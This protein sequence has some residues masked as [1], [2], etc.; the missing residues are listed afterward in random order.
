MAIAS[1]WLRAEYP[2]ISVDMRTCCAPGMF[3]RGIFGFSVTPLRPCIALVVPARIDGSDGIREDRLS[4][5]INGYLSTS[6]R[7]TLR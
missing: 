2:R 6:G 7:F 4:K 1:V 5:Y 3:G